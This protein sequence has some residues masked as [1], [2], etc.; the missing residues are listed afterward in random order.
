MRVTLT[1]KIVTYIILG[2]MALIVIYPFYW[3]FINSIKTPKDIFGNKWIPFLQFKPTLQNWKEELS[4]ESNLMALKN[5]LI[6]SS[7]TT[8]LSLIL[9][10][11]VAFALSFFKYKGIFKNV[12]IY[13]FFLTQR[14]LPPSVVLIPIFVMMKVLHLLDTVWGLILIYTAFNIPL[15]I[16]IMREM[17]KSIPVEIIEAATVDGAS[18]KQS[19]LKIVMPLSAPGLISVALIVFAFAW[20]ELL[21]A[22]SMT[23]MKAKTMTVVIA[24]AQHTRGTEFWYIGV[25]ALLVMTI[26]VVISI[27]AQKYLVKG[28]T[29]GAIK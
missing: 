7:F 28:L 24:G 8:L 15:V 20:N 21:F 27:F 2:I 11:M 17:F 25:R 6:V 19:L 12:D 3:A 16:V 14:I 29:L 18:W 22:L 26:P 4:I 1:E 5:S 10:T 9:G 23:Y 13:I